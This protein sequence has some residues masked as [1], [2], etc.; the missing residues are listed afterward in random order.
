MTRRSS[1]RFAAGIFH[2]Y[3]V[4]LLAPF[5]A[6]LV[7]AGAAT[8]RSGGRSMRWFAVAA[9]VPGVIVE[10]VVLGDYPGN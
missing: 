10:L 8:M 3:Y 6:A 9:A 2:P 1:S 4:S 7:G 5:T